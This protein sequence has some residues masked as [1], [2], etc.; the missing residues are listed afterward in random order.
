MTPALRST[1]PS[2]FYI[3]ALWLALMP[4]AF[5]QESPTNS[6]GHAHSDI[7][8]G[9]SVGYARLEE[10]K[11]DALN[12][13]FHIMKRLSD[14]GIQQ[15]FSIGAGVETILSN[16]NHVGAMLSIAVHPTEQIVLSFSQGVEWASHEGDWE[17]SPASHIEASYLIEATH[18]HYGP[19]IGYSKASDKQHYTIGMHFGIPLLY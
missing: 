4:Q 11:L 17:S 12:L 5:S 3:S 8:L 18:F 7:E 9:F 14:K 16:E 1:I 10:E 6:E 2:F 15:Y 19:V 13:H